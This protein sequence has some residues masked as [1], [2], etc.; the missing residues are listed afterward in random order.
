MQ[1][2]TSLLAMVDSS[3]GGKGALN[4]DGIK[5]HKRVIYQPKKVL[6]DPLFLETLPDEEFRNGLAEVIKYAYIFGKPSLERL[7]LIVSKQ[8]KD[9]EEIIFQCCQNKTEVIEKDVNDKGYRHCLNF[10]HTI[11]HAIELLY[12]LRHGEAISIGMVKELELGKIIGMV[13]ERRI[14]E[15]KKALTA[16]GLP[17]EF[18]YQVNLDKVLENMKY[19]K[20]GE[21]VF[22]F[23]KDGY[24]VK[25][26]EKIVRSFL[27]NRK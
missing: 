1:V 7:N 3:I 18:P 27:I 26:D 12:N 25:L 17:I 10:G 13:G 20:K 9:I 6:I 21:F 14:E 23:D 15:I 22:A 11:G 4:E 16:S 2:P 19:D 24:N 5:N 8:D